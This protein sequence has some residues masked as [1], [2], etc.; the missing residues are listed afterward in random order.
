MGQ[1][2]IT[3]YV[4]TEADRQALARYVDINSKQPNFIQY[5]FYAKLGLAATTVAN[6]LTGR[7]TAICV[8]T[9]DC[10]ANI[11]QY[12]ADCPDNDLLSPVKISSSVQRKRLSKYRYQHLQIEL[13]TIRLYKDIRKLNYI[14]VKPVHIQEVEPLNKSVVELLELWEIDLN[15]DCL[16][17]ADFEIE[18]TKQIN[19]LSTHIN[20]LANVIVNDI[21][22]E[23]IRLALYK[24][25]TLCRDLN[26]NKEAG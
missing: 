15:G 21:C 6:I 20:W 14:T 17:L 26:I 18:V 10:L 22:K 4:V 2:Y 19:Q 8:N 5:E 7:S 13:A 12:P 9:H 16:M 3:K 1:Y 25:S 24:D 11:F 23:R